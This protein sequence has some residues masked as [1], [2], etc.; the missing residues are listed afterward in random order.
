MK[1]SDAE[2]RKARPA[3]RQETAKNIDGKMNL[4]YAVTNNKVTFD[5]SDSSYIQTILQIDG[6]GRAVRTAEPWWALHIFLWH[7][8]EKLDK[9]WASWSGQGKS[10]S[11]LAFNPLYG[12]DKRNPHNA[13][14]RKSCGCELK[15]N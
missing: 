15:L 12:H 11:P 8:E 7:A 10:Q 3:F 1:R 6:L 9:T 14:K 2:P 5:S 4:W 13:G